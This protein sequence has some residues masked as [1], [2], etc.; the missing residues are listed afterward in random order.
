MGSVATEALVLGL[1]DA[2]G[3]SWRVEGTLDS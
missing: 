2:L 3:G 1:Q